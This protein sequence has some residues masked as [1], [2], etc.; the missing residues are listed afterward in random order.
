[1]K[2]AM[3]Q[4][5]Q[6][7]IAAW[8]G[9]VVVP[10]G[11]TVTMDPA[12]DTAMA[13]ETAIPGAWSSGLFDCTDDW[14]TCCAAWWCTCIPIAQLTQRF[15]NGKYKCKLIATT[16]FIIYFATIAFDLVGNYIK[17]YNVAEEVFNCHGNS[18]CIQHVDTSSLNAFQWIT[19][20]CSIVFSAF[21]TLL[22]CSVRAKIRLAY[23]IPV[24][25]CGESEDCC[26][27]WWCNP[28]STCQ[29]LRHVLAHAAGPGNNNLKASY[30]FCSETAF[31]TI[32]TSGGSPAHA[33]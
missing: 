18:W 19:I 14:S 5:E 12:M 32:G 11:V 25:C 30:E 20:V 31:P 13:P 28:C 10:A 2:Q 4:P 16:L 17:G 23:A 15:T 8:E 26:V 1:M 7:D 33:V 21:A 6:A 3:I 22:I 27:S 24:G 9:Q 29:I